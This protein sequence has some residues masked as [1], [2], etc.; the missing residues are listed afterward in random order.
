[1]QNDVVIQN[2]YNR[3]ENLHLALKFDADV[4]LILTLSQRISINQERGSI[5]D[6]INF[7]NGSLPI[8]KVRM[9]VVNE[10]LDQTITELLTKIKKTNW[11]PDEYE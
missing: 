9:Y 11:Q 7:L 5:F 10:V 1:M 8:S 4:T 6:Q 3:L 2:F